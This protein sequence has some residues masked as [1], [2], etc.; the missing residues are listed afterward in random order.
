MSQKVKCPLVICNI[1]FKHE[2]KLKSENYEISLTVSTAVHSHP[3]AHPTAGAP[4]QRNEAE[5]PGSD[6]LTEFMVDRTVWIHVT[7]N[8]LE[9]EK[10]RRF[11]LMIMVQFGVSV[12]F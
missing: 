4:V 5:E 1:Y 2:I 11:S 6:R 9:K 10:K 3:E 12:V 7:H 8:P